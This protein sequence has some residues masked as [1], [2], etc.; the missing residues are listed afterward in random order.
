MPSMGLATAA[1]K[2]SKR[3]GWPPKRTAML[4]KPQV[5]IV[6]PLAPIRCGPVGAVEELN[7]K[8]DSEAPESTKNFKLL[9]E[10]CKKI[11]FLAGIKDMAVAVAGTD[12]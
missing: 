10:S 11:R 9:A 7:G 2:K 4:R 6:E 3:K 8:M 1:C 5:G 12:F